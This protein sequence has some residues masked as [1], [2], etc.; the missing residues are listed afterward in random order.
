MKYI[1][2]LSLFFGVIYAKSSDACYSVQLKSFY[3]KKNSS[4]NF[5][6]YNYPNSCILVNINGMRSVRC[7]CF[8]HYSDA[9]NNLDRLSE[10]YYDAIIVNTYKRRFSKNNRSEDSFDNNSYKSNQNSKEDDFSSNRGY[11]DK[12]P[13]ETSK[14]EERTK[15]TSKSY[16]REDTYTQKSAKEAEEDLYGDNTKNS[17]R[18]FYG[19][20]EE[21]DLYEDDEPEV[22]K[23]F[24]GEE[25]GSQNY[26]RQKNKD[27]SR[28]NANKW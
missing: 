14:R 25:G 3:L 13:T 6:R 19:Q 24:Y 26:Y 17:K 20:D 18:S 9:E 1:L 15:H 22:R 27:Y 12:Y 23:T 10:K 2:I 11:D 8:D 5:E 16:Q 28:S 7:G 4:Y 21:D